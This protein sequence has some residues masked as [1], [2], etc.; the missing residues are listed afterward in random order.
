MTVAAA[1]GRATT[2]DAPGRPD[3]GPAPPPDRPPDQAATGAWQRTPLW[4]RLVTALLVVATLG[5]AL[6]GLF[7]ARM[8]R[9]FLVDRVDDELRAAV[10]PYT[11]RSQLEGRSGG[12]QLPSQ[13]RFAI[14]DRQ[15]RTL[16]HF[17]APLNDSEPPP[18]YPEL[19]PAQAAS[20]VDE[21]FTVPAVGGDGSW[22]VLARPFVN[23]AGTLLVAKSLEDVD[24]TVEGLVHIDIIVGALVL[25]G[26]AIAGYL[27]VR[28]ALR[29]LT[30]I[31]ETAGAIAAG[32]LGRRIANQDPRTEVGRLGVALNAML[33]QIESALHARAASEATARRSEERMR[34]FV[35][36]ASHELRTPLTSIRGFAELH[37][38]GAV[39]EAEAVTG[40]LER[41]EAEAT[42]MGVLVD[43][44]LLL[45]RLDQQRPLERQ[46][47]DIVALAADAVTTA[48]ARAPA[49]DI[50]LVAGEAL[51]MVGDETRLRQ[52][53]TNLVDNALMHTPDGTPVSV[54]VARASREG[55]DVAVLEVADRGPGLAP[56]QAER[57][58]ERFYRTDRARSRAQGGSGLGLSIVA[59]ITS[60]HGG[61]VELDTAPGQ[62][63]TFRIV[64]PVG[65][66]DQGDGAGQ[67][68]AG[69]DPA[70]PG[71]T[72]G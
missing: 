20:R 56:E 24:A 4:L 67:D 26:L 23:G 3:E 40:L 37:R 66:I 45:A 34:Q 53:A 65:T 44:L 36:D 62:G 2:G 47:V 19:T 7:G 31:E 6:T 15:G 17:Y 64:I 60:A 21:P 11:V 41:I 38:Q 1:P 51:T 35:A 30:E 5:L 58:F 22:R 68:P 63:A 71:G 12:A 13:F 18:D 16:D 29:P 48:R 39:T 10:E 14:Q 69:Q 54:R 72:D 25:S 43:D 28:T 59:A 8:L 57:V 33:N 61:T 32:D 9:N 42:R 52:V 49:R 50:D 70:A 27:L 46:P 55:R